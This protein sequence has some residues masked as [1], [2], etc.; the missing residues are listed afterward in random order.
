[1]GPTL[2]ELVAVVLALFSLWLML[3]AQ[4]FLPRCTR[5]SSL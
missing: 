3:I 4:K 2:T 5:S 1:M